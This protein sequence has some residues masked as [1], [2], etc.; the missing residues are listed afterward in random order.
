MKTRCSG[1]WSGRAKKIL[2]TPS[3]DGG[4][5]DDAKQVE[6]GG[7]EVNPLR[8][9]TEKDIALEKEAWVFSAARKSE[10]PGWVLRVASGNRKG[11]DLRHFRWRGRKGTT[12]VAA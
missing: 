6:E 12:P 11:V 4:S 7:G 10:L 2:E 5:G 8:S 3:A 9:S 1:G